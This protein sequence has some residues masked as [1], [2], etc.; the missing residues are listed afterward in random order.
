MD[1]E[2]MIVL[3]VMLVF[4]GIVLVCCLVGW[5]LS[6]VSLHKIAGRRGIAHAWL[7]WIPVGCHW[8]L[9]SVSDQYQHLVQG[10]ITS[11]RKILLILSLV[12]MLIGMCNGVFS[13]FL[14]TG[15][16]TEEEAGAFVLLSAI[17]NILG[18]GIGIATMV[19]FHICN[20]D[21]YRSCNPQN[22]VVFLVL[23]IVLPVCQP[24]FYFACRK[25]D[26]GMVV[27]QPVTPEP[28][29]LPPV[30]PEF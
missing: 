3:G 4:L 2:V 16:L 6:S 7:A 30:S 11:R 24:F 17:P 5:I 19:F 8:V 14:S 23:G 27:P 25:K 15:V 12:S 13:A 26:L 21:L 10:K 28:A 18:A 1:E 20:F 29:E 22:A 9:G